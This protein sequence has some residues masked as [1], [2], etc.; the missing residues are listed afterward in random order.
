MMS[1]VGEIK[2]SHAT[3]IHLKQKYSYYDVERVCRCSRSF[4]PGFAKRLR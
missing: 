1:G 3:L 4:H 2:T